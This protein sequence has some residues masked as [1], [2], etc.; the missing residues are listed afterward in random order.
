MVLI[1]AFDILRP[2]LTVWESL[3]VGRVQFGFMKF[4]QR[5]QEVLDLLILHVEFLHTLQNMIIGRI[6]DR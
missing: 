4:F 1:K 3:H 5:I 6:R 2:R